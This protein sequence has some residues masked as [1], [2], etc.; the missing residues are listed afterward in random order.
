[1]ISEKLKLL[2]HENA[3][4]LLTQ[5]CDNKVREFARVIG[6][7]EQQCSNL[8][9]LKS[10]VAIGSKIAGDIEAAFDMRPGWLSTKHGEESIDSIHAIDSELE[11]L[12]SKAI[13]SINDIYV[14]LDDTL[15]EEES[16]MLYDKIT[17]M[18]KKLQ[19]ISEINKLYLPFE[20]RFLV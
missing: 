1:M 19:S 14:R 10:P 5:Y 8:L 13:K 9:R 4:L 7:S 15:N 11:N 3:N 17:I 2:R 20:N 12:V 18:Q 6:K 16:A